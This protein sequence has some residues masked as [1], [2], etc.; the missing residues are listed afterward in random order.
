MCLAQGHNSVTPVRLE[1]AALRS[2]VK[3][4]TTEPLRS[5]DLYLPLKVIEV[6]FLLEG[7]VANMTCIYTFMHPFYALHFCLLFMTKTILHKV[8]VRT[9][10][11]LYVSINYNRQYVLFFH[12]IS[13]LCVMHLFSIWRSKIL[14]L[15]ALLILTLYH[16]FIFSVYIHI[17]LC[18]QEFCLQDSC[19]NLAMPHFA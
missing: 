9:I 15:K 6:W 12:L 17:A 13:Y 1:P 8:F 7:S 5:Q 16:I 3:H 19:N 10:D 11:Y 4:S 18:Y 2:R 14:F